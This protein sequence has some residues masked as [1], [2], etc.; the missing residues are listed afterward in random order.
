MYENYRT[1]Y[2]FIQ[3]IFIQ[4]IFIQKMRDVRNLEIDYPRESW[5]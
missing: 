2:S 4:K 5:I 1:M 3:K